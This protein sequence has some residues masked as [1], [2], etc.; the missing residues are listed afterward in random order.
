MNRGLQFAENFYQILSIRRGHAG[1]QRTDAI[2]NTSS[3]W[4]IGNDIFKMAETRDDCDTATGVGEIV[5]A[6]ISA[7]V[8]LP[9]GPIGASPSTDEGALPPF[10]RGYTLRLWFP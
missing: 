7:G 8:L 10:F 1:A 2:F 3:V 4:H 9:D 5:E 6:A